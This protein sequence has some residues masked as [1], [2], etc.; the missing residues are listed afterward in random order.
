MKFMIKK[1]IVLS[2]IIIILIS[3]PGFA[4]NNHLNKNYQVNPGYF[5]KGEPA[6]MGISDLGLDSGSPF[7]LNTSSFMGSITI[8]NATFYNYTS[9]STSFSI[10]LNT[11]FF[12]F[13]NKTYDYW[14]QDVA[15]IN[16][17][18]NCIAFI[19]N[20]W[21]YSSSNASLH[22]NS[23]SGNGTIADHGRFYYYCAPQDFPGNNIDLKYPARISL[24]VNDTEINNKPAVNFY[25]F[26]SN[27]WVKYDTVIFN[28]NGSYHFM[29]NG[30]NYNPAGLL[31]DAELIIGGPGN[32]SSTVDLSSNILLSLYY[33]N[34][35]NYQEINNAYDYGVD[36]AETVSN[37][38][39]TGVYNA[40]GSLFAH[41]TSGSG[42]LK[43]IYN[44]NDVGYI[45]LYSG[46]K[47]GIIN[48]NGKSYGFKN[49]DANITLI[50]GKYNITIRSDNNI[51]YSK[52]IIIK[53]N[54]ASVIALNYY[55]VSFVSSNLTNDV[56]WYIIINGNRYNLTGANAYI[57]LKNGTYNYRIGSY[58]NYFIPV[59]KNGTFNV[60]GNNITIDLV[61]KNQTPGFNILYI[62]IVIVLI[63][64]V[65]ILSRKRKRVT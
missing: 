64:L 35:N 2:M 56:N 39:D 33:W 18:D 65:L 12:I 63:A 5:I 45:N 38:T 49:G 29:V 7:Y 54:S 43:M 48:I 36:T 1:I 27:S 4:N 55:R 28:E 52:T 6:P 10:Q 30:Y 51:I 59:T 50:P 24:M 26:D 19:D 53:S 34:G 25:Y 41:I 60:T 47:T 40:N 61:W 31:S 17:T 3:I 9:K 14:I 13:G 15:Y 44:S 62:P 46:I 57:Y 16:T 42:R 37:V 21:N 20:V 32:G 8:Y 22:F 58:N 23:L 11:N